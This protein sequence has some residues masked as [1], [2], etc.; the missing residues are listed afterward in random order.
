MGSNT[1]RISGRELRTSLNLV[2]IAYAFGIS[3]FTVTGGPPLTGF[4]RKLGAGDLVYGIIMAMPVVGGIIQVFASYF[5]ENTGKRKNIF[6]FF[7]FIHRLVWIPIALIPLIVPENYGTL[8]IWAVTVLIAISS[9]AN[10][11]VNMTFSSWMGSLVPIE[12]RGRFFSKRT[13]IVTLA[14]I[15]GGLV[16][17]FL[18]D[19]I[20]GFDGYAVVFI[21]A[22]LLGAL[23]I[24]CFFWIK[25]PPMTVSKEKIPFLRLF[26]EPFK[27]KNYIRYIIFISIWNFGVNVS[28]PFFNVYM[29]EYLKMN[30]LTIT[31]FAQILGNITTVLSI[32]Y[33]GK[34]VDRYGNKPVF[35]ICGTVLFITPILWI[36]TRPGNYWM[37][38]VINFL[39]GICWP[40]IE[41]TALNLSIWLA[42]EKNRSIYLA[43]YTLLTSVAG[44]ALAYVC[45]GAFMEYLAPL[46]NSLHIKLFSSII[47]NGFHVLFVLSGLIRLAAVKIFLA[48]VYEENSSHAL[49]VIKDAAIKF[50]FFS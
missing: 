4:S 20:K 47:I 17:S 24:F 40:G 32:R 28:G 41:M 49:N 2:I 45:G 39:S 34:A 3:F 11:V 43:T 23:D 37:I 44:I 36:F 22:S 7:G 29:I 38:L 6:L 35:A 16:T 31:L 13:M 26:F 48:R 21:I 30:F 8:R 5:L 14:G 10:S 18:L 33:W 1:H 27:S 15:A 46:I 42:P 25:D 50:R 12:I 19:K 9:A